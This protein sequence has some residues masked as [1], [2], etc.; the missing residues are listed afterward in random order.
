MEA[1]TTVCVAFKGRSKGR[2]AV[3]LTANGARSLRS[4]SKASGRMGHAQVEEPRY[5]AAFHSAARRCP[6]A[7]SALVNQSSAESASSNTCN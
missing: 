5:F 3:R 4:Y 6:V 2:D 7:V 1:P